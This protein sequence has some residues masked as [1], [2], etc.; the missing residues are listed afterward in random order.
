MENL[1][2]DHNEFTLA[3]EAAPN[4]NNGWIAWDVPLGGEMDEPM[5]DP[6]FNE[7]EMDDDDGWEEDDEWLIAPV[8]PPRATVTILSTY[9]VGGPFTAKPVGHPLAIM[10]PRFATQPQ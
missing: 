4:N 5:V 9:E 8:T 1:P 6:E 3:A 7:E 10:A 2:L